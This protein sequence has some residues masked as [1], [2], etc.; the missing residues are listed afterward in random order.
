[1]ATNFRY[2][3]V[4][5]LTRYVNR[6]SDFDKKRQLFN[7]STDSNLHTFH[8]CGFVDMLFI[9]GEEQASENLKSY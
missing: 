2:C 9:N 8:N 3:D 4:P 6:I 1:M 7:P 5:V